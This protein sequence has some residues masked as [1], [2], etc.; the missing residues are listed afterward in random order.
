MAAHNIVHQPES[1]EEKLQAFFRASQEMQ[2]VGSGKK[3]LAAISA[4]QAENH[5]GLIVVLADF[6]LQRCLSKENVLQQR[7]LLLA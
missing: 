6:C 1:F 7:A 5:Q 3:L 2:E 4:K